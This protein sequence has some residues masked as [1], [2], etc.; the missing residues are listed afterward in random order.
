MNEFKIRPMP[1]VK[2]RDPIELPQECG[3]I[4]ETVVRQM[5]LNGNLDDLPATGNPHLPE[6]QRYEVIHRHPLAFAS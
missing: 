4:D 6:A 3:F 1:V 5:I 2:Q